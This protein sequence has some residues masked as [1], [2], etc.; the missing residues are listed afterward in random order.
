MYAE[1]NV[2]FKSAVNSATISAE[3]K[4]YL[5][6]SAVPSPIAVAG[7]RLAAF[8]HNVVGAA[9]F[10]D[11]VLIIYLHMPADE[12]VVH[13]EGI[14]IPQIKSQCDK[15]LKQLRNI[16]SMSIVTAT[17]RIMIPMNGTDEDI[18]TGE[19]TTWRSAFWD[20]LK[21]KL[22]SKVIPPAMVAALAIY[23]FAQPNTPIVSAFIALAATTV[24]VLF[25]A[26]LAARSIKTWKWKES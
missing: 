23:Y 4:A 1:L 10:P 17:A 11:G 3:L 13:V 15:I 2:S 16:K 22:V 21:E 26:A 20:S 7:T 19:G 25:E 12:I 6:N 24:G 5:G 14:S 18:L 9:R 8:V